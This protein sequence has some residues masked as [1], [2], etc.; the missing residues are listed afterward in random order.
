MESAN[1]W[2]DC[3]SGTSW[4][5]WQPEEVQLQLITIPLS[6]VAVRKCLEGLPEWHVPGQ[7]ATRRGSAPAHYNRLE[8]LPTRLC[9]RVGR[10]VDQKSA[11]PAFVVGGRTCRR[12][13]SRSK[14]G[15]GGNPK[16]S[17][18]SPQKGRS[19][20]WHP[21]QRCAKAP[22]GRDRITGTTDGPTC[23]PRTTRVTRPES[24]EHER[25]LL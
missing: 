14:P 3:P 1:A 13:C 15:L 10:E 18:S 6:V 9:S 17:S 11:T 24:K 8:G 12:P 16:R 19:W 4:A 23:N 21:H 22:P 5:R 20:F 7:V 2:K 25:L